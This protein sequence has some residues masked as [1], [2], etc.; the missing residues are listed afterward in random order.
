MTLLV[1]GAA[2]ASDDGA[3]TATTLTVQE[4]YCQSWS[5]VATAFD[6]FDQVDVLN[7]GLDSVRAYVDGLQTALEGLEVAA[8]DNFQPKVE[9]MR[10]SLRDLA[11]TLGSTTAPAAQTR[12]ALT[13]LDDSWNEL[14]AALQTDCPSVSANIASG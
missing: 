12:A 7:Q 9:A 10:T 8:T 14:V 13:A 2:C 4:R 6:A 1:A 5:E 11:D 3:A